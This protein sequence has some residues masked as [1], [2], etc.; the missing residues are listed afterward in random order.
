MGATLEEQQ[1]M[2]AE[3]LPDAEQ[4]NVGSDVFK[5]ITFKDIEL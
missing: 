2:N 3:P 5:G 4:S 1:E